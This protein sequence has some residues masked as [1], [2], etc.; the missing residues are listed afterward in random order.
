MIVLLKRN[1][2]SA[3]KW[4]IA[5]GNEMRYFDKLI[6]FDLWNKYYV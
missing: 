2:K 5:Q 4:K 6:K 1:T 3:T